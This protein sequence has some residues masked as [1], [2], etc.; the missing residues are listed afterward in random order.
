MEDLFHDPVPNRALRDVHD[1][2]EFVVWGRELRVVGRLVVVRRRRPGA[3]VDEIDGSRR[4]P[5]RRTALARADP[6]MP[7]AAGRRGNFVPRRGRIDPSLLGTLHV[8]DVPEA[9]V[10]LLLAGHTPA[11]GVGADEVQDEPDSGFGVRD[12]EENDLAVVLLDAHAQGR[13][14]DQLRGCLVLGAHPWRLG[15]F[16]AGMRA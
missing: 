13:N 6:N 5:G 12:V 7:I 8:D 14:V 16:L 11:I 1:P 15:A 9:D 3:R 10:G 4:R 2:D